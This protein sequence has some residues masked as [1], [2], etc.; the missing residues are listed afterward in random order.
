MIFIYGLLIL[1]LGYL[2]YKEAGSKA[3]LVSGIGFGSLLI[4]SSFSIFA[5]KAS[6]LYM[7]LGLTILLTIVFCYRFW[8]SGKIL[9]GILGI[10]SGCVLAYLLIR[11]TKKRR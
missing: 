6:G 4:L 3:S 9:P 7:S 2:G 8:I 1:S 11:M 10:L 5:K